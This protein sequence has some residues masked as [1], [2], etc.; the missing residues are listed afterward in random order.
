[1]GDEARGFPS[2]R[3]AEADWL[4]GEARGRS[5]GTGREL[6]AGSSPPGRAGSGCC[7][8]RQLLGG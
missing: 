4:S 6:G 5:L 7:R 2:R 3:E 8:L 1:M